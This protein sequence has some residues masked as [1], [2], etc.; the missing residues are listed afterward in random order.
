MIKFSIDV[1]QNR[2]LAPG[3]TEMDAVL[4]VRSTGS[5][6]DAVS[7]SAAVVIIVDCSGSMSSPPA[8]IFAAKEAA[9]AA[10]EALRD[11]TLFAVIA[12]REKAR[13]VYPPSGLAK[14][15]GESRAAAGAAVARL[16]ASGGTA[17]STWL[18]LADTLFRP[19]AGAIAH[20][21]LL[22]DG[23]NVGER[24]DRLTA[25]LAECDGRFRCDCRGIGDDWVADD[26]ATIA[27]ALLGTAR[28]IERLSDLAADFRA[29]ARETMRK[30]VGETWLRLWVPFGARVVFF[31]QTYPTINDLTDRA[32]RVDNNTLGYPTGAWG[33]EE[34]HYHLGI[35]DLKPISA[36]TA[37]R[38]GRARFVIDGEKSDETHILAQ[39]TDD[40]L[41]FTQISE[42]VAVAA[43]QVEL[44]LAIQRGTAA[45]RINDTLEAT[46]NLGRA[47]R[48]A[49]EAGNREKLDLLARLVEIEDPAA[50]IVRLRPDLG[51]GIVEAASLLSSW[52]RNVEPEDDEDDVDDPGN[53][54]AG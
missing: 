48:F 5:P 32:V 16:R 51:R 29:I 2:F 9:G 33:T 45:L 36:E 7:P 47:V 14:A 28:P 17:M 12:G 42:P 21:I 24:R 20:A 11:G 13:A 46:N 26:L 10:I 1:H 30:V 37:S 22:T 35:G 19:H 8:K 3:D 41:Q 6:G 49:Y 40:P 25:V 50:G 4:E 52:T 27:A 39:W 44:A 43:G 38:V 23:Q 34:R 18:A 31:K 15:S 54:T 53:R